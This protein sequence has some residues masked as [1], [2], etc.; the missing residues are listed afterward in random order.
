MFAPI[1]PRYDL[2][3]RLMPLGQDRAWRREVVRRATLGAG[4][5]VLDLGTGT[6]D[7]ALEALRQVPGIL[8]VGADFTPEMRRV[9]RSRAGGAQ[10]RWGG[11]GAGRLRFA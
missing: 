2:M 7:I 1:A 4:Q 8:A 10:G 6:G 3:N 9:G 11:A 5:R